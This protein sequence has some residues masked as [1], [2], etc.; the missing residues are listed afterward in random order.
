MH[1]KN[2][3]SARIIIPVAAIAFATYFLGCTRDDLKV[4]TYKIEKPAQLANATDPHQ[5]LSM[6]FNEGTSNPHQ[7][8][9]PSPFAWEI[10]QGWTQQSG[11]SSMR[12]A[13]F[14]VTGGQ[15]A[16]PYVTSIISLS[17]EA[18]GLSAN[19]NRWR[20]Q[21]GLPPQDDQSIQKASR[22]AKSSLGDFRWFEIINDQSPDKG[23]L[24]AVLPVGGQT[25]FVKFTAPKDVLTQ[26]Q[27]KFLSLCK[28][29]KRTKQKGA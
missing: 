3:L 28:S 12:L 18:G 1:V 15:S 10:P 2:K 21:V 26:N 19:V 23:M 27:A 29:I 5:N 22:S 16:N 4:E 13:T 8:E 17:G 6:P 11:A 25:L 24:V 7:A 14:A 9:G 20:E